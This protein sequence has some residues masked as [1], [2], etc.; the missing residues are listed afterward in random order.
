[1]YSSRKSSVK[2]HILTKHGGNA[3]LV[4]FVDYLVGR[5]MGIYW[6]SLPPTYQRKSNETNKR[7]MVD[8]TDMMTEEF[9]RQTIRQRVGNS[10]I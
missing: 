4:S 7:T 1:M 3:S 6:P 5:K 10:M 9:F 2:R 8:Y